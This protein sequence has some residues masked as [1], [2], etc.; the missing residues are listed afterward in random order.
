MNLRARW[1][2]IV[3]IAVAAVALIGV[4]MIPV[5]QAHDDD[6]RPTIFPRDASPYGNTYGEWS[7][8]WWQWLMAIPT[9]QNPELRYHRP[10][11]WGGPSG[12]GLLLGGGLCVASADHWSPHLHR[13]GGQGH[14]PPS[15]QHAVRGGGI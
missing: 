11:L 13:A 10:E 3:A 6:R 15:Y 14:Y 4:A 9:P 2:H 5:A 12:P 7:A 1:R 8:R